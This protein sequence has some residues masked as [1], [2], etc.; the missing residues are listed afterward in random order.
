MTLRH[1]SKFLAVALAMLISF[2]AKNAAADQVKTDAGVVEG[3]TAAPGVRVFRGVPF[4]APPVG[5]LR[6]KAP[7]PVK[8]WTGVRK[9]VDFGSRCAQAPIYSDMIFR[10]NPSQPMSE[11]CL[12]LNVW[13]PAKSSNDKLP[14]MVWYYGGGFQ[15]GSSSEPR[16][17]GEN[18]AKKGI[19]VVSANYRLGVFGF[20]SHPELTKESGHNASGNYGLMDQIAALEWVKRNI[21]AFGGDPAKVTIAGESA[22]SLSVSALMASPLAK[23]LFRGA[24]GES[25]AF[26]STKGGSLAMHP[27]SETEQVG[28]KLMTLAGA[29]SLAELRAKSSAEL[30]AA[31][32]KDS[33]FRFWPNIDGYVLP[34]DVAAIFAAGQQSHV[35]LLAGWNHD[36]ASFGVVLAKEPLTSQRF[37]DQLHKQYGEQSAEV[38]KLYPAS[39]NADARR[40]A[41]DLASDLFL[42]YSTWQWLDTQH[43]TGQSAV[44]RY[45]F[46]RTPPAGP[47]QKIDGVNAAEFGARHACELEYVFGALKSQPNPWQPADFKISDAIS[48]YWANFVKALDPNGPGLPHWPAY[49]ATA[50]ASSAHSASGNASS[51]DPGSG[52]YAVM[53]FGETIAAEPEAHRA[54]YQFWSSF[55][56]ST[57]AAS[58]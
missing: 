7:Q 2:F 12:Y 6:W 40:S 37:S 23:G 9:A 17:D 45:S 58:R 20:F 29:K 34:E 33:P 25:G 41:I 11:D 4:A 57:T 14:V 38:A 43:K 48:S 1:T 13:T 51:G 18:F 52:A 22:G 54:R 50:S 42:V 53:H 16:Y 44:Y 19:I 10:D 49:A 36:E 46:D 30:L 27:V 24:I 5:D 8:P 15:A 3:T 32:A 56:P 26:F 35:P 31:V 47:A 39:T 55:T 28:E 21:A